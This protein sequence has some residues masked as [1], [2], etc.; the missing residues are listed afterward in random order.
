VYGT[1]TTSARTDIILC[2]SVAETPQFSSWGSEFRSSD[3]TEN[4]FV[5]GSSY[6]QNSS[7]Y[8]TRQRSPFCCHLS[9][10]VVQVIVVRLLVIFAVFLVV[11]AFLLTVVLILLVVIIFLL[12]PIL[13]I[14]VLLLQIIVLLR[15]RLHPSGSPPFLAFVVL[16][17]FID[18][19]IFRHLLVAILLLFQV[20]AS[21]FLLPVVVAFF[22]PPVCPQSPGHHRL[23]G[24]LLCRIPT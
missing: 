16:L 4:I 20:A 2:F 3:C 10:V 6:T 5:F 9:L 1:F 11:T 13:V 14:V 15:P 18:A 21:F 7:G 17:N 19:V 23:P 22:P 8:F 24:C 12:L